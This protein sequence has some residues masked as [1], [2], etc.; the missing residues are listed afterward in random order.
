M[1]L[2]LLGPPGAGKGTQ[3]EFIT[4]RY[5]I[6][7]IS[8]GDIF[9][10]NLKENTPLGLQAKE[11]MDKGLLVPDELT[12]S[13]VRDRLKNEDCANGYMLDGFPRTLEQADALENAGEKVDCVLNIDVDFSLLTDRITGRR[14]CTGCQASYHVVNLPPQ[15]EGKCDKC[16]SD[17]YQREDDKAET[18]V[19]R[20]EEYVSKT[21]P[22][23]DYYT[24]RSLLMTADGARTVDEVSTDI[25]LQL[26]QFS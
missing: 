26:D 8:T 19:K 2:I 20:L 9:R 4:K 22:L 10:Q 7:H 13:M 1:K 15:T 12:V 16:G 21:Q 11:Y 5:G 23:I 3:A 25:S 14:L 24:Q 17:L 6:A 18:V